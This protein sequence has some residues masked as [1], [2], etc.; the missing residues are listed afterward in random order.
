MN[1]WEWTLSISY[2]FIISINIKASFP[3]TSDTG[4][5]LAKNYRQRVIKKKKHNN[6]HFENNG[7][8][9]ITVKYYVPQANGL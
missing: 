7:F 6:V 2:Y 1:E 9:G 3:R 8:G 5:K 4:Q